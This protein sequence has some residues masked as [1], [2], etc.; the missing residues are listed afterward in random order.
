MTLATLGILQRTYPIRTN[1]GSA[2][3]FVREVGRMQYLITA[4]HMFAEERRELSIFFDGTWNSVPHA[5]IHKTFDIA[6]IPL[7]D[8][9][10]DT[11]PIPMGSDGMMLG[12]EV[13]FFGF[14]QGLPW[15]I[16]ELA[17][18]E[19]RSIPVT[20][21]GTIAACL[22]GVASGG[23]FDLVLDAVAWPGFSGS[24][25]VVSRPNESES[26]VKVIGIVTGL[27]YPNAPASDD[28]DHSLVRAGFVQA[29]KIDSALEL[30]KRHS[31]TAL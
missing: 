14:P 1:L 13:Q 20:K 7:H 22:S 11:D 18:W 24:P 5:E 4:A 3:G 8:S 17:Q 9:A 23:N 15:D 10:H 28:G 31:G 19:K 21:R 30:M 16:S 27:S 12:E 25:I 29:C 6:V 26:K 2:T